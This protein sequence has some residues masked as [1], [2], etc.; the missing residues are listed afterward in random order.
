MSTQPPRQTKFS[1]CV[2]YKQES[3]VGE[4]FGNTR[5]GVFI[6]DTEDTEH[7][8]FGDGGFDTLEEVQE[9]IAQHLLEPRDPDKKRVFKIEIWIS[10][11]P[12]IDEEVEFKLE[13]KEIRAYVK[14]S[15]TCLKE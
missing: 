6:E 8:D 5:D 10:G 2:G 13:D 7:Y 11:S 9:N 14:K 1:Y 4:G 3:A 15:E 12:E